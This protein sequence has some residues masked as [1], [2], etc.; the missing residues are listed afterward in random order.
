MVL[1]NVQIVYLARTCVYAFKFELTIF[2]S[3]EFTTLDGN[4][5]TPLE[6]VLIPDFLSIVSLI[7]PHFIL[8]M[9]TYFSHI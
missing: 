3:L 6:L 4:S 9:G 8:H 7:T 2:G 1:I 5:K